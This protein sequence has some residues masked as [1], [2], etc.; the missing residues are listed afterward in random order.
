MAMKS[1]YRTELC[2][3]SDDLVYARSVREESHDG[4]DW[5]AVPAS[6]EEVEILAD[7]SGSVMSAR[8]VDVTELVVE[9]PRHACRV[10]AVYDGTWSFAPAMTAEDAALPP[11]SFR[12]E[13]PEHAYSTRLAI[14]SRDRLA[15]RRK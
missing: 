11:W 10:L 3:H 2:G 9:S 14:V 7:A 12:T 6:F 15:V 5:F 4:A 8:G 13:Q 1:R